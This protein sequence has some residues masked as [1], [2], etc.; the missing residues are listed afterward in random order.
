VA[1]LLDEIQTAGIHQVT[2]NAAGLSSGVY[3]YRLESGNNMRM[4]KMLLAR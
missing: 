2:F 1:T 4:N 3:Y